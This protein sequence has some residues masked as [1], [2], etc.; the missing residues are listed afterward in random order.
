MV[1]GRVRGEEINR[2][3]LTPWH[4]HI[5]N[6]ISDLSELSCSCENSPSPFLILAEAFHFLPFLILTKMVIIHRVTVLR[7]LETIMAI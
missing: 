2:L 5:V 1:R 3:Y 4:L 6:F 7:K